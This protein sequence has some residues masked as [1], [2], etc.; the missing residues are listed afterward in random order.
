MG[1]TEGGSIT[2]FSMMCWVM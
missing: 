2:E 1:N